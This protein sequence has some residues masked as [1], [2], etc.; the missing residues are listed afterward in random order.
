MR[1]HF[2]SLTLEKSGVF[3]TQIRDM[4]RNLVISG[5]LSAGQ[6]IPSA[7]EL[8]AKWGTGSRTVHEAFVALEKE[9]LLVRQPPKGTYVRQRE[10]KLTCVG[11]YSACR[12]R[13]RLSPTPCV[14][15]LKEELHE[16][17]IEMDLWMDPR[18]WQINLANRGSPWSRRRSNGSSR[19]SLPRKSIC[20]CSSGS[21]NCPCRRPFWER[22]SRF[23]IMWIMTCA[24]FVEISLRELARQGC[25]SVGL[26]A[27]ICSLSVRR[28]E[29]KSCHRI[30]RHAGTLH[31]CRRRAGFNREKRLDAGC[32]ESHQPRCQEQEHFGYEQFLKLW[33][34]P[35]KPEGLLVFNDVVARGVDDGHS[36]KTGARAG[37]FEAGAG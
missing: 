34:Q 1:D 28:S 33:S 15:M 20:L 25:R 36:G 17:G 22:P 4:V 26:I 35:E 2:N 6:K 21:G 18:P 32:P 30:V 9:G 37:R 3:Q 29:G 10:K 16:D 23:Q 5:K 12:S 31:G 19:P 27:P 7:R 11:V 24:Q 14:R 13:M 8:A